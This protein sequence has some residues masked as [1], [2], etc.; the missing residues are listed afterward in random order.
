MK[1]NFLTK[2]IVE[3]L[4]DMDVS[5]ALAQIRDDA[6]ELSKSVAKAAHECKIP[7]WKLL[8]W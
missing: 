5:I 6:L 1:H 3:F 2:N 8:N 4:R 7:N